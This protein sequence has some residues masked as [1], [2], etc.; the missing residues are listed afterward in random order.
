VLFD[1]GS[2]NLWVPSSTCDTS[3]YPGCAKHARYNHSASS[4]YAANGEGFFLPYGSGTLLGFESNDTVSLGG[5]QI[6]MA[7]FG[8]ATQMPGAVWG[9]IPFDGILGLAY[10]QIS[11][12][13]GIKPIF[14]CLMDDGLVEQDLFSFFLSSHNGDNTSAL[15]LGGTD[16]QYYTGDI[17]YVKFNILQGYVFIYIYVCVCVL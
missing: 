16:S 14:D 4:T 10:P 6:P 11:M 12:P 2:S 17:K 13:P 7:T 3:K 1:T 5:L 9:E 8:E 15:I